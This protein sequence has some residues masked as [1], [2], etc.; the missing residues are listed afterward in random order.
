MT[1]SDF[2]A[3]LLSAKLALLSCLILL[4]LV[5]PLAW[6]LSRRSNFKKQIILALSFLPLVLPPTVLG[7]Y[8]LLLLGPAGPLQALGIHNLLFSFNGLL[9]ASLI[10]SLPFALQ[11]LLS[12]FSL[13]DQ[14]YLDAARSLRAS[15]WQLFSRV[16]LPFS[17]RAYLLA[18]LLVFTH[19]LGEFGVVLMIGG[20]IPGET[21][22]VSVAIF[23]KV[24]NLEYASAHMMSV[25][26]IVLSLGCL[27]LLQ[28]VNHG[29][30]DI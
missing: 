3:L 5:S 16:I 26:L 6:W 10:Y 14:H 7:F 25:L 2:V 28:R 22:M 21:Q 23:E 17:R 13:I 1:T 11:P 19:T 15:P 8:L 20:N 9:V 4:P 27:L 18:G 29:R 24:E 12:S 30:T